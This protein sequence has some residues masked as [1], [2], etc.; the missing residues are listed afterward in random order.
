MTSYQ[1]A[2]RQWSRLPFLQAGALAQMLVH[3]ISV[4]QVL[5]CRGV[6]Q[7]FYALQIQLGETS[8]PMEP[9][10]RCHPPELERDLEAS[11]LPF[12]L[13]LSGTR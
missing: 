6:H 10:L 3:G 11:I 9:I 8:G 13:R 12:C 2:Y 5:A 4:Q 1:P 7:V